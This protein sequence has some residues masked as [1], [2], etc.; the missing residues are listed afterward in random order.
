MFA[1]SHLN[2]IKLNPFV[3]NMFRNFQNKVKISK[4][5]LTIINT[6]AYNKVTLTGLGENSIKDKTFYFGKLNSKKL[7]SILFKSAIK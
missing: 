6:P 7:K 4:E 5:N 3:K 2:F 1:Y